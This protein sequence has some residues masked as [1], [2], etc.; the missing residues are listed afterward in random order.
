MVLGF[1]DLPPE[2]RVMIYKLAF[3]SEKPII[4]GDQIPEGSTLSSQLLRTCRVCHDEGAP[5]LSGNNVFRMETAQ[6]GPTEGNWIRY[7]EAIGEN[8][9]FVRHIQAYHYA[10]NVVNQMSSMRNFRPMLQNLNSLVI[11]LEENF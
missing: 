4:V 8:S 11:V 6:Y 10:A 3:I 1:T 2:V 5:V 9:K 7:F